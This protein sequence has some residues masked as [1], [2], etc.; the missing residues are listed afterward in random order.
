M[1]LSNRVVAFPYTPPPEAKY[2]NLCLQ[3]K[4]G[5]EVQVVRQVGGWA[6]LK[7]GERMGLFPL[8]Y[9]V[10]KK[11]VKAGNG[12]SSGVSVGCPLENE[13]ESVTKT[14]GCPEFFM[15]GGSVV[16]DAEPPAQRAV[17]N[18]GN[19]KRPGCDRISLDFHV[20]G[21]SEV[22]NTADDAE[23][24]V[25]FTRV[26]CL[27]DE[28]EREMPDGSGGAETEVIRKG[29]RTTTGNE[30]RDAACVLSARKLPEETTGRTGK[31]RK[32]PQSRHGDMD[33][34]DKFE[35]AVGELRGQFVELDMEVEWL[36]S[37][38]DRLQAVRQNLV[39]ACTSRNETCG[40]Q[41][42][43]EGEDEGKNHGDQFD[44]AALKQY[45]SQLQQSLVAYKAK[46]DT[47]PASSVD[48]GLAGCEGATA[49]AAKQN[50]GE[51]TDGFEVPWWWVISAE[52]RAE[53]QSIREC[54]WRELETLSYYS[55]QR[56]RLCANA[57]RLL[58][59]KASMDEES[60]TL[61][62]SEDALEV[63]APAGTYKI[64]Y[65]SGSN[66]SSYLTDSSH[67][68]SFVNSNQDTSLS[69]APEGSREDVEVVMKEGFVWPASIPGMLDN[70]K[71]VAETHQRA[72]KKYEEKLE[73]L[74]KGKG[75][76]AFERMRAMEKLRKAL[77]TGD[78]A[79]SALLNRLNEK[80][81]FVMRYRNVAA[82]MEEQLAISRKLLQQKRVN[83]RGNPKSPQQAE[84]TN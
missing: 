37:V 77:S 2:A 60:W 13:N 28:S 48:G 11:D 16:T 6:V 72:I 75:E 67:E 80:K 82:I 55:G 51:C 45:V 78:A 56:Q 46:S 39:G 70:E 12:E 25:L 43:Q 49:T 73:K 76:E 24:N 35:E 32:M 14:D 61:K 8:A 52:L 19:L 64:A 33:Y 79:L 4:A 50:G 10:K 47:A 26:R 65:G 23:C 36:N 69:L 29:D 38:T 59:L 84:P 81:A 9:T 31:L 44:A 66:N 27:P 3:A 40:S 83:S 42:L 7:L 5:E 22:A 63:V 68:N 53:M 41:Q 57:D 62:E 71:N 18:H 17:R 74:R 58:C 30:L 54:I 20:S 34:R 21:E 15:E 1:N